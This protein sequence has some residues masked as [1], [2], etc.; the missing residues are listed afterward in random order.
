MGQDMRVKKAQPVSGAAGAVVMAAVIGLIVALLG[1]S[2]PAFAVET[3]QIVKG[4][5]TVG[6]MA[7]P[8]PDGE[9]TV[10]Y[11]VEDDGAKFLNAKLG[12]V[13]LSGKAVKQTAYFR[14]SRSKTGAGFKPY[15]QCS[16]PYY[17]FSETVQNQAGGAQDCWHI[18]VET[19]APDEESDRQKAI[20]AFAKA[21]GV[22]LPLTVIGPRFHY[23]S[24]QALLQASYGWTPD[25]IVKAPKDIKVWRFQD[26]TSE[27]VASEP[28]KKVIMTKFKRW[29]AGWRPKIDSVFSGFR[30]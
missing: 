28:R 2:S 4:S 27:A 7:M 17:F 22:F 8:L 11:A 3:G 16:Q 15:A 23:A 9:W 1:I 30:K 26:W 14:V 20:L 25:L 13:L 5:V 6:G 29:G 10:Y 24:S 12:L 18:L 21:H 19:L